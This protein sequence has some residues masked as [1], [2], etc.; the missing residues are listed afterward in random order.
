MNN[1]VMNDPQRPDR[2]LIRNVCTSDMS[3]WHAGFTALKA[4]WGGGSC[5][6]DFCS[7]CSSHFIWNFETIFQTVVPDSTFARLITPAWCR[8]P[9][10]KTTVIYPETPWRQW[11]SQQTQEDVNCCCECVA[12]RLLTFS[13]PLPELKSHGEGLSD[14]QRHRL[15]LQTTRRQTG[16]SS[17]SRAHSLSHPTGSCRI[18]RISLEHSLT[19]WILWST[20]VSEPLPLRIEQLLLQLKT[21][22]STNVAPTQHNFSLQICWDGNMSSNFL[23]VYWSF[24]L[25]PLL[26]SQ[27]KDHQF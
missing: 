8:A 11:D 2:I 24:L 22:F 5:G 1:D 10:R 21:G 3:R 14:R 19:F 16:Q 7:F 18:S 20:F 15:R 23:R 4:V 12:M 17:A 27:E 26:L 6:T 9:L 13:S 25:A